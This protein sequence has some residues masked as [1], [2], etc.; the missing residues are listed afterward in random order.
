MATDSPSTTAVLTTLLRHGTMSRSD[1]AE[2]I[3]RTAP[4]ITK[5]V[6]QLTADGYVAETPQESASPRVGRPARDVVL[7]PD[8]ELVAGLNL[9]GTSVVATVVDLSGAVLAEEVADCPSLDPA[10]VLATAADLVD[11]LASRMPRPEAVRTIGVGLSGDIDRRQGVARSSAFLGWTGVAIAEPLQR[12]TGRS[13]VVDNDVHALAV[14]ESFNGAGLDVDGLALITIGDGIGCSLIIN[15]RIIRGAHD[16]AGELGHIPVAA[17]DPEAKPCRC[18]RIGCLESTAGT[19][20]I[21]ERLRAAGAPADSLDALATATDPITASVL[22]DVGA[23]IGRGI[24]TV[25]SL[26]GPDLVIIS[27]THPASFARMESSLRAAI[28]RHAFGASAEATIM[29]RPTT[30]RDWARGAAVAA[31]E[32]R[33]ATGF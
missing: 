6:Q 10:E 21:L 18:G 11:R 9:T 33:F 24:A 31:I 16:V 13:V 14:A 20:A 30:A 29:V 5:A 1:L 22:D 32:A 4:S 3:G 27:P 15:G 2:R 23:A 26:F 7:V 25:I 28:G 8:R 17:A 12:L 19:T